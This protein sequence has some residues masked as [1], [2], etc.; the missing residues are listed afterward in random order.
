[1]FPR[2]PHFDKTAAAK[3]GENP[4]QRVCLSALPDLYA[5]QLEQSTPDPLELKPCALDEFLHGL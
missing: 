2:S 5:F 3:A 4:E 1:M